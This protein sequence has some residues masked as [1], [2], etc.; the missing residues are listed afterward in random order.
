MCQPTTLGAEAG[1]Y[2]SF[3]GLPS[4]LFRTTQLFQELLLKLVLLKF[5]IVFQRKSNPFPTSFKTF[6]NQIT[7]TLFKTLNLSYVK[8]TPPPPPPPPL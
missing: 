2:Q 8:M 3:S 5:P 7:S 6:S 4:I 1:I